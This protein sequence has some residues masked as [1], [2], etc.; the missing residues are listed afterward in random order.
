MKMT[1]VIAAAVLALSAAGCTMTDTASRAQILEAPGL[2][3]GTAQIQRSYDV[4]AVNVVVPTDLSVSEA[5]LYY[6]LADIV[7]RGDPIGNRYQQVA[8]IIEASLEAGTSRLAGDTDVIVTVELVRW[9]GMT[10]KA[11]FSVG[12]TYA[13]EFNLTVADAVTGQI[14][15]GPRLIDASLPAPGGQAAI[16]LDMSGQTEKVRVTDFLTNLFQT[17]LSGVI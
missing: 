16:A 11:R 4:Q 13:M 5:N 15:E 9:H 14:I 12:G 7:W 3:A 17:Q 1:H 6:P 8:A 2:V 10:E